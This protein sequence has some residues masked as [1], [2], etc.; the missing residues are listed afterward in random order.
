MSLF[1]S[2]IRK[3][4]FENI[5]EHDFMSLSDILFEVFGNEVSCS[6]EKIEDLFY[7]IPF[8]DILDAMKW[9][10]GDTEVRESIH[11]YLKTNKELFFGD[12]LND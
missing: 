3:L 4:Y 10:F 9:G 2:R 7:K 12:R 5:D 6:Y 11:T 1:E 8:D